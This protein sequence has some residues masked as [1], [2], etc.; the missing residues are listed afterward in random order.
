MRRTCA[1]MMVCSNLG[2]VM[3]TSL[4]CWFLLQ[5][6]A[7]LGACSSLFFSPSTS[8]SCSGASR[9][10]IESVGVWSVNDTFCVSLGGNGSLA[11]SKFSPVPGPCFRSRTEVV[12]DRTAYLGLLAASLVL[13][14]RTAGTM[15]AIA[16]STSANRSPKAAAECCRRRRK[17]NNGASGVD[18]SESLWPWR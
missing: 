5:I 4:G 2:P 10:P 11:C 17:V 14:D 9:A 15:L 8:I 18:E 16:P 1:S 3:A 12:K 13:H 7:L 6:P